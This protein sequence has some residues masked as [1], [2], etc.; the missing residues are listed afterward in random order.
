MAQHHALIQAIMP[1]VRR[2]LGREDLGYDLAFCSR[3]GPPQARWLEPDINDFL[4]EL[5]APEGQ[6]T[7]E[8]NEASGS[9]KPSGVVVVPIGFICDHMEVVY[10][11]D[12]EA[13]ETAAELGIAYKRAETISTDPAF[14]SSLVD[15]LEERAAQARGENPFRMTVTGTGPFHTVCPQDCCLAP[16]RPAHSQR[17]AEAGTQHMGAHAPLS[18]DGP[19]RV[20][21]QSAIQQEE[22]MAFLNRRAAQP[23]ESTENNGHS[24]AA[25]EHVAEHAPHH[26]AAHSYVPDPRDRT[27]IDLDEVN[28][29]QHYALYSVFAL[30]EFLP[31]DDSERAHIVA[32]SLDYVKSAGAEIRGFY[33]VS[34][35]RAEA[36]LM[37]WWLPPSAR[38]RA[39][40]VP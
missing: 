4:R 34:G 33:D 24:E 13:K 40:E 17:S 18:S 1:E 20:A 12:T 15:V 28:G 16:A 19:V 14:V 25:P 21:G 22:S 2:V 32:E 5:I 7:G 31:A 11:L 37:V 3:S 10:D 26:H 35:F 36:D 23:A 30:G 38:Q 27:D 39:G 8:G 6:S 9:G 29:K